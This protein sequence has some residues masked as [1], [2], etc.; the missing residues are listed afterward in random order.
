MGTFPTPLPPTTHHIAVVN[1]VSTM[2]YQSL[3]SS[4]PWIV[5]SPLEF[6]VL[7]DAMPPNPAEAAYVAIQSAS[8]SSNNL[9]SLA[10][11]AFSMPSW[12]DSLSSIVD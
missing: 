5:P 2:P 3:E 8:P 4:D 12:L 10:P 1:M 6:D 7:S 9:H 11:D